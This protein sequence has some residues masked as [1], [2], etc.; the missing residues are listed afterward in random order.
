MTEFAIKKTITEGLLASSM[1]ATEI[2][3]TISDDFDPHAST[4]R[5]HKHNSM[6]GGI[7]PES[8]RLEPMS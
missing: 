3:I 8:Y 4:Y 6:L 2:H 1:P 5:L 7:M